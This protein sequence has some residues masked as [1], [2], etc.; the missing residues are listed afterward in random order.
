M[1]RFSLKRLLLSSALIAIGVA[2]IGNAVVHGDS[3]PDW[4]FWIPVSLWIGSGACVGAGVFNF[5]GKPWPGA[6]AG[7]LVA[8]LFLAWVFVSTPI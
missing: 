3:G 5:Y 1:P 2:Y 8:A 7:G 4:G 6:L